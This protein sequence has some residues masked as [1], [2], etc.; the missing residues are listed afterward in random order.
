MEARYSFGENW[1]D[2]SAHLDE[3]R[4]VEAE[5]SLQT[6]LARERLDGLRFIDIGSGSG[7]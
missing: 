4:I 5:K 6:L 2:Y 3:G 1:R 7:L